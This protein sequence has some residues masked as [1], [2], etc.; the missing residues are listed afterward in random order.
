MRINPDL[1]IHETDRMGLEA[2][3]AIPGFTTLFRSFMKVW[4]E[5]QFR[6]QNMSSNLRL[7]EN[8]M[9]EIYNMLPPICEKLGIA[10]PELYLQLNVSPNASTYGDTNPFIVITTGML[11]TVPRELIPTVLAHECGHIACRH[12]LYTTMGRVI[13]NSAASMIDMGELIT[14]PVQL[15]FYAW[16][17]GSEYSADRAAALYEGSSDKVVELMMRLAGYDKDISDTASTEAFLDQAKEYLEM[18]DD[19]KWNKA[20][21][22]MLIG[23][24]DHPLTA[25][26]AYECNEWAKTDKFRYIL[27]QAGED[28]SGAEVVA[29]R[30]ICVP[31]G[32]DSYLGRQYKNVIAEFQ[33]LGFRYIVT[34]KKKKDFLDWMRA[35]G[36]IV[37]ISIDGQGS[38]SGGV[39][40][41]SNAVVRITY[42]GEK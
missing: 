9:P 5:K 16:M 35:E 38:F 8:Q 10:V 41:P 33:Q 2:L 22:F 42:L 31:N 19:S 6:I 40:F 28:G 4:N 25:V 3:K 30:N 24:S 27:Q 29:I 23:T 32:S 12:T 34:E 37:R 26:R 20:L 15:A 13:L 21:E 18:V 7:S 1:Y 14:L 36:E 17:R 39:I 11:E